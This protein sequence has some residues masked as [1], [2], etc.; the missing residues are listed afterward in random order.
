MYGRVG[1][2]DNSITIINREKTQVDYDDKH[3]T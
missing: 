3:K 2:G 1:L